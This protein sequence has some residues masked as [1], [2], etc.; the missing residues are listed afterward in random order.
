MEHRFAILTMVQRNNS[1]LSF[2]LCIPAF[3]FPVIEIHIYSPVAQGW[4][5]ASQYS[6]VISY[7]SHCALLFRLFR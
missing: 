4:C 6:M 3:Y 5:R 2:F 7:S 1:Y